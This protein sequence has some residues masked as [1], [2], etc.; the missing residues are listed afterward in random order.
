MKQKRMTKL[1]RQHQ[2]LP[3]NSV[4]QLLLV[5]VVSVKI[6]LKLQHAAILGRISK[7]IK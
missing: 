2:N 3:S 1:K 6:S 5:N 4:K 7:D